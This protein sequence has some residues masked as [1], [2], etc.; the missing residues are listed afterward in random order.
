MPTGKPT[1]LATVLRALAPPAAEPD[2]ELLRRF[3]AGRDEGAFSAIVRRHGGLVLEVCRSVLPNPA[4]AD[5]AFQATFLTLATRAGAVRSPAALAAWLHGT[6]YRTALKARRSAA[7]RR[8]YEA[9]APPPAPAAD[10]SWAEVR[11]VIHAEVDR[12]PGRVRAAI[13]LCYL[14]GRS[15]DDAARALGLSRE[16]V[17]KRLER[18]RGLLRRALGRRGFGP[19]A[20]LAAAATPLAPAPAALA[21]ATADLALRAAP[22]G[23]VPAA[24]LSLT[25]RGISMSATAKL[26]VATVALAAMAV[27]PTGPTQPAPIATAVAAPTLP[28]ERKDQPL[29]AETELDGKW[30]MV[31]VSY[32]GAE[33]PA[34]EFDGLTFTFAK[35]RLTVGDFPMPKEKTWDPDHLRGAM[36]RL[37]AEAGPKE[38]DFTLDPKVEKDTTLEGIY[39]VH[40]RELR[41]GVRTLKSANH[42]RPKGY[43]TPSGTLTTYILKRVEADGPKR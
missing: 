2:A 41:I 25:D 14:L 29:T 27:V 42:P 26:L 5:D 24:V 12:L 19:A 34:K 10:P 35:G 17:K 28:P 43:A 39:Q 13:V 22:A 18:G 8:R 38:I 21:A 16:G 33:V 23:T 40:G 37:N 11:E 4:D 1:P 30:K 36:F 6:A 7:R 9:E 31:T 20:V 32:A 15:Q 3:V